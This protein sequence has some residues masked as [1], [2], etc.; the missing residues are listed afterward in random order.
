MC[1]ICERQS[2][3]VLPGQFS[4]SGDKKERDPAGFFSWRQTGGSRATLNAGQKRKK[5]VSKISTI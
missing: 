1:P 5:M 2:R 3:V 4:L